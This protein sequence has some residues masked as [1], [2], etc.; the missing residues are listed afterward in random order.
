MPD[1]VRKTHKGFGVGPAGGGLYRAVV[2]AAKVAEE[3]QTQPTMDEFRAQ[4][5]AY[6]GTDFGVH[7][8][9]SL[10]RF[11]DAIRL[12]DAYRAGRVLLAGDAAHVHPPLGGQG[13][14]LGIQDAFHLGWKLA[15]EVGG[16]APD[17]LLDT[18]FAKPHPVAADVLSLTRAQAELIQPEAGPQAVRRLLSSLLDFD[19]VNALLAAKVAGLDVR[20]DFGDGPD[21]L[22]RCQRDVPLGEDHLYGYMRAGRALLL[23]PTGTL[24]LGAWSE[25]VDLVTVSTE[26]MGANATLLRPDGHIAWVGDGQDGLEVALTRW[27]GPAAGAS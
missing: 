15:A 10:T 4:L 11:T 25:R 9:R 5:Q 27:F 24:A 3:R 21:R 22:G 14:N 16:W 8:P 6:A 2:P 26:E 17:G 18:Y 7:S 13:L 19:E 20:Y 12:A 1:E 23:N